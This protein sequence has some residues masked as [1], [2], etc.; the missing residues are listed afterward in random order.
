MAP[1]YIAAL[2]FMCAAGGAWWR[3]EHC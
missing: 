3:G 1:S 2:L